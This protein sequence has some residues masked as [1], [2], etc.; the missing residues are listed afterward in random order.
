M[1]LDNFE[2]LPG[3]IHELQDG[4]L[5]IAETNDAPVVLV[6]GTASKGVTGRKVPVVR[7]NES[8]NS[9]GTSGTLIRGMYETL[10]G[11][12]KNTMLLRI[13]AKSAILYGVGTDD[14]STS[15]TSIETLL[16]DSSAGDAYLI[17]YVSPATLGPNAQIGHLLI[18]NANGL[19]VFDNNPGGDLIDLGEVVVSGEFDGGVDIGSSVDADDFVSMTSLA[20]DEVVVTNEAVKTATANG[21]QAVDL[22]HANTVIGSHVVRVDGVE[23]ASNTFTI[24]AGTGTAGVDQ[25]NLL[26][27][28]GIQI[29]DVIT[30]DYKYD[31]EPLYNLREGEDGLGM[32]KMELYEALE[33]AYKS[34]ENDEVDIVV[35]MGVFLDDK[36]LADGDTI[37]LSSDL[38][39]P[40][41]RRYPKAGATGDALGKLYK[42][43]YQGET[44]Y[45]WNTDGDAQAEIYPVGVGSASATTKIDGSPLVSADF[46]EV[47]FAY[48]LANFC[49][50]ISVN[51]NEATGVIGTR[52]PKSYA[53]KDLA[54]WIGKEPT[55]DTAGKIV[56][57]GD[58][59]VGN[60]FMAGTSTR[61]RGFVATFSGNLPTGASFLANADVIRDRNGHIIDI[62]KYLSVTSMPLTFFNSTDANGSGYQASMAAY[63]GGFYSALPSNSSPTNKNVSGVRAPFRVSKTKLNS[64]A[65][66]HFVAVKQKED[67]IKI[68]DAPTA[69]RNDSDFTR[70]T[71]MR[72]VA[73]VID[74]VRAVAEPYIGE[75][76][77]APARVSLETGIT[78]E[79]SRLQELGYIQ[80]FEAK[81]SATVTQQIQGD[82]TVELVIVPAFEL[83]KIT[84]I[85]SLAKQ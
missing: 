62:G 64:L 26:V 85:T 28:A 38:S 48:Q 60:K 20:K 27:G 24:L 21:A 66:F 3:I 76:N 73:D 67:A 11:G 4:G 50:S 61:D 52:A 14:Q 46:K 18:K 9:F 49:F 54:T 8:E 56:A 84:I 77:T 6:L 70:L 15:P 40:V 80:R 82:A 57:D 51:D 58:G 43:E 33:E 34:L 19:V 44:Y 36:N 74:S 79:L 35:P 16:K 22:D 83:R 59:L 37:I 69:A 1:A 29:G 30:A 45:F 2:S 68:S 7:P 39:T 47:N 12:S 23:L 41:G 65:K 55:F 25:I 42:E 72:I 32:S 75:P 71:T 13:G 10:S 81:V 78:R 63:Y 17:R 5:Q 53:A 31:A